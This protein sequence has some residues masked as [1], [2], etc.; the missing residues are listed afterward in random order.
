MTWVLAQSSDKLINPGSAVT[1]RGPAE[2][3]NEGSN[4]GRN[5][6]ATKQVSAGT[7]SEK[8][9]LLSSSSPCLRPTSAVVPTLGTATAKEEARMS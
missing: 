6:H 9:V 1:R 3:I 4:S 5:P 8:F 7:S 2:V